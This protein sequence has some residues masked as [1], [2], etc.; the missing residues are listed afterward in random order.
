MTKADLC[1]IV[2]LLDRSG[3]MYSIAPDMMGGFDYFIKDQQKEPGECHLTLTQFDTQGIDMVHEAIDIQDV[4]PLVL[5][6][7]G[8]TPLLDALGITIVKVGERFNNM[9]DDK[10]PGKVVFIIITDGEENSSK[11]YTLDTIKKMVERQS[12]E[13]DWQFVYLGANVDAFENAT[14]MGMHGGAALDYKANTKGVHSN[15]AAVSSSMSRHR[16]APAGTA[17][18]F[19]EAERAEVEGDKPKDDDE[20]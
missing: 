1:E 5:E 3:S 8:S 7:R 14:S 18:E 19:S 12:E 10:R 16:A 11:E 6:P 9:A 20:S 13:F 4:P 2:V 17:Y 15:F